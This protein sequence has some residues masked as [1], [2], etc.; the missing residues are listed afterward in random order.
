MLAGAGLQELLLL[1]RCVP[2]GQLVRVHLCSIYSISHATLPSPC[3]ASRSTGD[4][5]LSLP[6]SSMESLFSLI[7]QW[8]LGGSPVVLSSSARES[9]AALPNASPLSL[10]FITFLFL[11]PSSV[12]FLHSFPIGCHISFV[13]TDS[14]P[15]CN[16]NGWWDLPHVP[17]EICH[18][19]SPKY[20][21]LNSCWKECRGRCLGYFH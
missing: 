21:S 7:P 8:G 3:L 18:I 6:W 1:R 5:I 19:H 14:W 17:W 12:F 15:F 10:T 13:S 4:L 2:S 11:L 16:P 9:P 20:S